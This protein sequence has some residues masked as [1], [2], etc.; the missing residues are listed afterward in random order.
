[1]KKILFVLWCLLAVVAAC[2]SE[3]DGN[4]DQGMTALSEI[5]LTLSRSS[6]IADGND[7]I[8][9]KVVN[10]QGKEVSDECIFYVN[11]EEWE[12]N[13]FSTTVAGSYEIKALYGEIWSDVRKLNAVAPED[14]TT[15]LSSDKS[16]AIVDGKDLIVLIL[17]DAMEND[18]TDGGEFYLDGVKLNE[19]YVYPA[20]AGKS[21]TVTA[22]Y[23]GKASSNEITVSG[24]ESKPFA[25]RMLLEEWTAIWCTNC[26]KVKEIIDEKKA[27][28]PGQVMMIMY[29]IN[30]S[31]GEVDPFDREQCRARRTAYGYDNLGIPRVILNHVV[32][33]DRNAGFDAFLSETSPYGMTISS[34]QTSSSSLSVSAQIYSSESR[35]VNCYAV[36]VEN[37]LIYSQYDGDVL[38]E[39]YS[40]EAVFRDVQPT[41]VKEEDG[42]VSG[43][44]Y[45][46]PLTLSAGA[47]VQK[48]F[49]LELK[50][51]YNVAN[52]EVI[53][54]ISDPDTHEVLYCHKVRAGRK[55]GY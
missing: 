36:L 45:G 24:T 27:P 48:D 33:W 30:G 55:V 25:G 2:T 41:Y 44:V 6:I 38:I 42:S 21:Y 5:R 19:P 15:T 40:H 3:E 32:M 1:M 53:V 26:P 4:D 8:T 54:V 50:D 9:F 18:V 47:S 17:K 11:G 34:K 28:Y 35:T 12:G 37:N 13:S 39:D 14:Y 29:H 10:G 7:E 20:E 52:C 31:K 16:E 43:D 22:S 51:D 49:V 46:E 23:H